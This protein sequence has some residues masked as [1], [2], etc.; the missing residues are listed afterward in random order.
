MELR[1]QIVVVT[2][3]AGA[4]GSALLRRFAHDGASAVVAADINREGA[5]EVAASLRDEGA[6]AVGLPVDVT[7][8]ESVEALVS[9]VEGDDDLGPIGLYCS[10]AG[11]SA[12]TGL[13]PVSAWEQMWTVN[14][15]SHVN[16]VRCLM[17]RMLARGSGHLMITASSA[18]LV[19]SPDA[20]YTAAKHA[21]VGLARWLAAALD[22]SG[23]GVSVLCPGAIRTPRGTLKRG[24]AGYG[25]DVLE[26]A[27][28]ADI[29]AAA[30]ARDEFL[31]LDR[32]S[33]IEAVRAEAATPTASK[34]LQRESWGERFS[35]D[36]AF[37]VRR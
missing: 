28:L 2:G 4:I 17:P 14:V 20:A 11:F 22:G 33:V 19:A 5:E 8:P 3:G 12:D 32:P 37:S 10:H 34:R 26:P 1:G 7:Q 9:R 24:P 25:A 16:A 35:L 31:I 13:G 15:L 30:L 18:G 23:V 27:Q 21:A 6:R 36:A 29:V